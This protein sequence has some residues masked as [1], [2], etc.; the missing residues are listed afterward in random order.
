[1]TPV[2]L[3]AVRYLNARPLICGLDGPG[4]FTL[5]Y[6]VPSECARLLHAGA[7]DV[8]L[9]PSIE[10]WRGA[11]YRMVPGPAVVSR[12]RV[13]SVLLYST[14]P[15]SDIRSIALDISSRTSVALVRVLC[16]RLFRIQ[17]A[18]QMRPPD[19]DGM[20]ADS[21]AAL[22]IG[23][24]ALLVEWRRGAADVSRESGVIEARVDLGEAW[25]AMTGLP[26]VYAFWAGRPGSLTG[27]DVDVLQ[28]ARDEGVRRSGEIAREYFAEHP[29]HQAAGARYLR[30]N[31]SYDLGDEERAGLQLFHRYAAELGLVEPGGGL[32]F[33]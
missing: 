25:T 14:R 13:A 9:I 26:F 15:V 18:F 4:R 23:D 16:A 33:Y 19:L 31:I 8:G 29:E 2:R 28:Q 7:I 24:E 20:L 27:A 12:G 32:R 22:I 11:D 17:P 5:R 30:D 21:D 1:M 10:Y 3:G 6:D